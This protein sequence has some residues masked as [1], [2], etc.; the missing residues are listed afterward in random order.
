MYQ[1]VATKLFLD[2]T[3]TANPTEHS[4]AAMVE[5]GST[6]VVEAELFNRTGTGAILIDL[7]VS[8]DLENWTTVTSSGSSDQISF[9][10][11]AVQKARKTVVATINSKY[12]R[13]QYTTPA[14]N[15]GLVAASIRTAKN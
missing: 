12:A 6:A 8:D 13:L 3:S 4:Q 2:G 7:Q 5:E 1:Q 11:T 14:S 9:G 15:T 10:S